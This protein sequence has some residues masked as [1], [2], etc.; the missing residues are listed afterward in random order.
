MKFPEN[1]VNSVGIGEV[2]LIFIIIKMRRNE[3]SKIHYTVNIINILKRTK[4]RIASAILYI[5][6]YNTEHS[7]NVL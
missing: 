1:C 7:L 3:Y 4:I 6:N 5:S 2:H